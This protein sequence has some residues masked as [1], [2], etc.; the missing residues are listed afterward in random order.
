MPKCGRFLCSKQA[1]C[2]NIGVRYPQVLRILLPRERALVARF[3]NGQCIDECEVKLA[4]S[5]RYCELRY[6]YMLG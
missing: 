4:L 2:K 3:K 5:R 6:A 1:C